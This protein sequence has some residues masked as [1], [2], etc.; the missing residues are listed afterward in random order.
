[1]E[2]GLKKFSLQKLSLGGL[3]LEDVPIESL[4][5]SKHIGLRNLY[6]K[7]TPIKKLKINS[8]CMYYAYL[9]GTKITELDLSG[10][11]VLREVYN[12]AEDTVNGRYDYEG[13]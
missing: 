11:K 5:L 9:R 12:K 3:H 13:K 4:D 1:M 7:N 8:D 2:I 10:C 6:I